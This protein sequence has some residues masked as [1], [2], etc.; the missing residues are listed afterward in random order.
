MFIQLRRLNYLTYILVLRQGWCQVFHQL[1]VMQDALLRW[2]FHKSCWGH[3][4]CLEQKPFSDVSICYRF[5]HFL[6]SCHSG[7][8]AMRIFLLLTLITHIFT[9]GVLTLIASFII[10][11][12]ILL[13]CYFFILLFCY[14]VIFSII[15]LSFY[16][17][18]SLLCKDFLKINLQK[19]NFGKLKDLQ[20]ASFQLRTPPLP[21]G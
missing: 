11:F 20:Q 4:H 1:T 9:Q 18:F 19:V 6:G 8:S 21:R 2:L 15:L 10:I 3:R 7:P 5:C 12:V 16:F 17:A 14:F 13:C